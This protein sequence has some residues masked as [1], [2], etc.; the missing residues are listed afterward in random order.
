M[1]MIKYGVEHITKEADKIVMYK[2]KE[3]ANAE[4]ERL[5]STLSDGDTVTLF[6]ADCDSDG[7]LMTNEFNI[8][9]VWG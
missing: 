8:V 5:A 3:K 2:D 7:K 9:K 4:A 1:G 6:F